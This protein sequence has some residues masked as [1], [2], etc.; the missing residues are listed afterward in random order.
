M[1]RFTL[2]LTAVGRSLF[3]GVRHAILT[4]A[5]EG[6][7]PNGWNDMRRIGGLYGRIFEEFIGRILERAF[8]DRVMRVETA[9]EERAD[10][11]I[12]FGAAF[13]VLEVKAEHFI[14]L[15]HASFMP[16]VERKREIENVGV[17]KAIGQIT[18]TIRALRAGDLRIAGMAPDWTC[19]P[20]LPV[21]VT[22][23]R[24]PQVHGCWEAL[25]APLIQLL[26]DLRGAGPI[27]PLRL[28][29]IDDVEFLPDIEGPDD[30]GAICLKWANDPDL[31]D[32]SLRSFLFANG[33]TWGD[34]CVLDRFV[35]VMLFMAD[36]L[37][38]DVQK[39]R[40]G[41]IRRS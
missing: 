2:N 15:K 8:P 18:N 5:R 3:D 37:G 24:L 31:R 39:L 7:L 30:F 28:I 29:S 36:R 1:G 33:I 22:E 32:S 6:K 38:L 16:L 35:S 21:I 12:A 14:G 9:A 25:Y 40:A 4:A 10:F 41:M 27:A 19:T 34:R 11:V 23:E 13:M 17:P 20:I 26:D